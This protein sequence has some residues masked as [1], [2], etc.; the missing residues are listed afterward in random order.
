MSDTLRTTLPAVYGPLLAPHFDQPAMNETRATCDNCQMCDQGTLP[1]EASA[2][3]FQPDTKCCTFHPSLPNYLVGAILR[4]E[5]PE[6]A[7]G[8]ARVQKQIASRIGITPGYVA[9]S[10]KFLLLYDASAKMAFG[11]SKALLCPYFDER[12][13]CTIWQHRESV[14]STFFC[15]HVF[16]LAGVGFWKAMKHYLDHAQQTLAHWAG[17]SVA[18]QVN[19]PEYVRGMITRYEL[20]DR[21]PEEAQYKKLW[22]TWVGRE[23][24]FYMQC[25]DRVRGMGRERYERMIDQTPTG[26]ELMT[27]LMSAYAELKPAKVPERVALNPNIRKLPIAKGVIMTSP[28]NPYDSFAI[29][30]DLHEVLRRF[31]HEATVA[32]TRKQLSDEEGIELDDTLLSQMVLYGFLVPPAGEETRLR[33]KKEKERRAKDGNR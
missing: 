17:K 30:G 27:K 9:P 4:D 11:R 24:E 8:R 7:E 33:K 15:K 31:S 2:M 16:G 1:P 10:R 28:D 32:A 26:R 3:F 12:G 21:P 23:E 5:R 6:M 13:L 25:Y 20:E 22:D 19:E 29:D 14:C 18:P